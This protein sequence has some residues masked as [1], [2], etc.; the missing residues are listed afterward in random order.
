MAETLRPRTPDQVRDAVQ[1]ALAGNAAYEVL[2]TGSKRGFGRPLDAAHRLDLSGLGGIVFYEPEELVISA[3]AGTPMADVEAALAEAGQ[4]LAF[5][6][7]NLATLLGAAPDAGPGTIGGAVACNLAGPRRIKSGAARDHVLGFHAVSGRGDIFKSGGRVVKNVTGFDLSKLM[8]GSFGTLGV[9]TEITLKVLPAPEKTRTVLLIGADDVTGIAALTRA[10]Q[11]SFEVSAAAHLPAPVA[12][13]SAVSYVSAAGGSISAVR[14]EG[15]GPSAESRCKSLRALLSDF[16]ETEELHSAN[17]LAL[18]RE[19][20]DVS[21]FAHEA[22]AQ[23]W[24][25]SVPPAEGARVAAEV[26]HGADGR[27]FYDWGGGLLW[28]AL[29]P[30]PDAGHEAVRGAI[31]AAGG[32]ATL[33]RAAPGVRAAVPVFQPQPPALAALTARTKDAFD[34]KRVLN[35]GRMYDG[36]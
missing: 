11:S 31:G 25:L 8:A 19:V 2:G 27:V 36:V 24:R 9:M 26:L 23:V 20:R 30:R 15:P 5:E 28:L 32:H 7:A 6:P 18:W 13:A 29:A 4:Q 3:G 16:G 34:P 14:V 22:A 1:W 35:L 17:S 10:L 33:I 12:A 21:Y